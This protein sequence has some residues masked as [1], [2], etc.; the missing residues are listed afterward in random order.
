MHEGQAYSFVLLIISKS[1]CTSKG[2]GNANAN[3]NGNG[4]GNGHVLNVYRSR[5]R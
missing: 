1:F 2:S 3:A 4:N 5:I